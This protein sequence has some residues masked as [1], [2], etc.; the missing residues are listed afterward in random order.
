[1][2]G[3]PLNTRTS[4]PSAMRADAGRGV[5]GGHASAGGAHALD[6]DALRD[7]LDLD[8]ASLDLLV[9]RHADAWSRREGHDQFADLPVFDEQHPAQLADGAEAIADDGQV[10][11]VLFSRRNQQADGEAIARPEARDGHRRPILH[12]GDGLFRA[13]DDLISHG[14]SPQ[15]A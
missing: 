12:V 7:Q 2:C 5:E 3:L 15:A 10:L 9:G 6:E 13:A 4:L 11:G 1:M 14:G 8:L